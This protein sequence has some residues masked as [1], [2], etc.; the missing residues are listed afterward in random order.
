MF[1][2]KNI[3]KPIKKKEEEALKIEDGN[4]VL[5]GYD[6]SW[7]RTVAWW[8]SLDGPMASRKYKS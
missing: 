3:L 6:L 2:S 5:I 1:L 8:A 7:Q 4:N